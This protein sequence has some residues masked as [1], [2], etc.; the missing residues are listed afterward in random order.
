MILA[1]QADAQSA[2]DQ[3]TRENHLST[4]LD[5]LSA[6]HA[7][8]NLKVGSTFIGDVVRYTQETPKGLYVE[9]AARGRYIVDAESKAMPYLDGPARPE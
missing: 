8:G 1:T 6:L 4:V 2:A 7:A 3:H 9:T 5:D